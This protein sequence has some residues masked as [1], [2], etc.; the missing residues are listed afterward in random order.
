MKTVVLD[1]VDGQPR[2][3]TKLL[4]FA[5]YYSFVPRS[6]IRAGRRRRARSSP[7]SATSSQASGRVPAST[8]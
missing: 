4:D 2:F 5:S 7:R 3:H 8:Q 6:A 1:R